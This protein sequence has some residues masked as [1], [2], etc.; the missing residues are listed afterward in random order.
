MEAFDE[1]TPNTGDSIV[2][3]VRV[4]KGFRQVWVEMCVQ[5][6]EQYP[7]FAVAMSNLRIADAELLLCVIENAIAVAGDQVEEG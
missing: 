3:R 1:T 5:P 7:P 4:P 2:F 6:S